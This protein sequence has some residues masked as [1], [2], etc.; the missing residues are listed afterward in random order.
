[1]KKKTENYKKLHVNNF[2]N[3]DEIKFWNTN[4]ILPELIEK[5]RYIKL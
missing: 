3:Q 5:N 1:M 2:D 4:I